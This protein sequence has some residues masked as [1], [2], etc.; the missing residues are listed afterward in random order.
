MGKVQTA[1]G[2][3]FGRMLCAGLAAMM[4]VGCGAEN[5]EIVETAKDAETVEDV[6]PE[7]EALQAQEQ[8]FGFQKGDAFYSFDKDGN[9]VGSFDLLNLPGYGQKNYHRQPGII[10]KPSK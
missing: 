2:K 10:K 4:L 1:M 5:D 6:A 8:G 3:A 7:E 9:N